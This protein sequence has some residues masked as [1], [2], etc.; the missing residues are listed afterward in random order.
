MTE[1]IYTQALAILRKNGWS[2]DY[3]ESADGSHCILG[4]LDVACGHKLDYDDHL[5]EPLN[6]LAEENFADRAFHGIYPS[7]IAVNDNPETTFAD[8]ESLLEKAAQGGGTTG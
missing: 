7:A 6:Q 8:I 3:R 1:N 4:A 5:L 2:K